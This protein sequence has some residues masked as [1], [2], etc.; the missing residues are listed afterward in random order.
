MTIC[1]RSPG[2]ADLRALTTM[3]VNV[4]P[5]STN[6]IGYF[7]TGFKYA[8]AVLLREHCSITLWRGSERF[9]FTSR[10]H[11]IR[12]KQFSL[13]CMNDREL[14]FTTELGKNWQPWH[15]YRELYCNA[16]DE[17]GSADAVHEG[18]V[19]SFVDRENET[20]IVVSGEAIDAAHR[21][22]HD[23]LLLDPPQIVTPHADIRLRPAKALFYRGIAVMKLAPGAKY[24]WNILS[25]LTL[26]ED[27]TVNQ[28]EAQLTLVRAINALDDRELIEDILT[29][30]RE[31]AFEGSLDFNWSS[32]APSESLKAALHSLNRHRAA[33]IN[34]TALY[35]YKTRVHDD[36]S[37]IETFAPDAVQAQQLARAM[38]FAKFLGFAVD[39]YQVVLIERLGKHLYGAARDGKIYIT[40]NAF[41]AGTKIVAGTLIEEFVHL[42]EGFKDETRALQDYLLNKVVTLGERLQ[43]KPL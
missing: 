25:P 13:V 11:D 42:R 40:R 5:N 8:I 26:T 39:D 1:F 6:P 28:W 29:T 33:E 14:G 24:T 21:Q 34:P 17:N 7:G 31:D 38:E 15:A 16:I 30:R 37:E 27:R 23:F 19:A 18:C 20:W 12:G 4:K 43:G 3:G 22:R 9:D 36:L 2:L 32:V 10:P 35:V 41:D